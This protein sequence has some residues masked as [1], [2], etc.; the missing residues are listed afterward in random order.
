MV[1]RKGQQRNGITWL[2]VPR[3]YCDL[4]KREMC[5][6]A[7]A[8]ALYNAASLFCCFSAKLHSLALIEGSLVGNISCRK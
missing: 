8:M 1:Q 4:E 3:I 2:K 7:C 6:S 5:A